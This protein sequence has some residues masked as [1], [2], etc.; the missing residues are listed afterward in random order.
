MMMMMMMMIIDEVGLFFLQ[1]LSVTLQRF[2]AILLRQ[3]FV[4]NGEPNL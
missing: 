2:S 3:S 1:W 4:E